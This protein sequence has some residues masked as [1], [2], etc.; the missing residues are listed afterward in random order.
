MIQKFVTKFNFSYF[1]Y[2]DFTFSKISIQYVNSTIWDFDVSIVP[3]TLKIPD[4]G[5][6]EG[7]GVSLRRY[8]SPTMSILSSAPRGLLTP[9]MGRGANS[10]EGGG[11][12]WACYFV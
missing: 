1:S 12:N 5:P 8:G 11:G 9:T 3:V 2:L 4:L 10:G 7:M 6:I